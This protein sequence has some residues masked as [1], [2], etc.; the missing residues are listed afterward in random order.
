M[1]YFT[2][3][4][5]LLFLGTNAFAQD[6]DTLSSIEGV[7]YSSI[8]DQPVAGALIN[9]KG[10]KYGT[11]SDSSGY[12]LINKIPPGKYYF[13][14]SWFGYTRI[15]T[16]VSLESGSLRQFKFTLDGSCPFDAQED[17][18]KGKPKLLLVGG[19]APTV[20]SD[21]KKFER[22]YDIEYYD[23]GDTPPAYACVEK[24]NKMVFKYLDQKFWNKWRQDVRDDVF[25]FN[26]E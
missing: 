9:I 24:Y 13:Y 14:V 25:N 1:K 15:D 26:K 3:I 21:Q 7:V 23:F 12:F 11:L 18:A 4:A 19:I 10:T 2:S 8:N 17:I 20:Y 6:P 5:I 22:K 16:S